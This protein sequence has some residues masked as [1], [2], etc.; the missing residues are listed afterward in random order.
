MLASPFSRH[1]PPWLAE[2]SSEPVPPF[3]AAIG[4]AAPFRQHHAVPSPPGAHAS[5]PP[6][7]RFRRAG[8]K[9]DRPPPPPPIP[10]PPTAPPPAPPEPP[11]PEPPP[12]EPPPPEPPPPE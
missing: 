5:G 1:R 2:R 8:A 10:P 11:P 7:A 9:M 12:P 4:E 3:V 6:A